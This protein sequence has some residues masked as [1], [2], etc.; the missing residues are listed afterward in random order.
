MEDQNLVAKRIVGTNALV[1][2]FRFQSPEFPTYFLTHAHSD[3]TTGLLEREG[4]LYQRRGE[5][6]RERAKERRHC[7]SPP[8]P[9]DPLGRKTR[10]QLL[11]LS[12]PLKKKKKTG[13]TRGFCAGTIYCSPVTAAL[14]IHDTPR[15]RDQARVVALEVGKTHKIRDGK[16]GSFE[17]TLVDANHCP[18]ACVLVFDVPLAAGDGGDGDDDEN[19]EG[20]ER[21]RT[22]RIVHTGD[23]RFHSSLHGGPPLLL[24]SPLNPGA[25]I[26]TLLL[27]TTYAHPRHDHPG[28]ELAIR[29]CAEFCRREAAKSIS[30]LQPLPS[31]V[32]PRPQPR[33]LFVFGSY[34]IGKERLYL[35][36]AEELG[37]KIWVPP[38]KRRLLEL[39]GLLSDGGDGGGGSEKKSDGG[40]GSVKKNGGGGESG[41][42]ERGGGESGGIGDR[43]T[44][45]HLHRR[46]PRSLLADSP[47]AAVLHVAPMG[48]GFLF[49]LTSFF[50]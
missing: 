29:A 36:V 35:G 30:P 47:T 16:C 15:V 9:V 28:Q 5:R 11:S 41:G 44:K 8:F 40:G 27:D 3:H 34:R 37:W 25:P 23:F 18:G 7:F 31:S 4:S 45:L 24:S 13:L 10:P 39:L 6:E 42:G 32:Q 26:D 50:L 46:Y 43:K 19:K 38:Q 33:P 12:P 2:G 21:T 1:D 14:I 48:K 49:S 17:V 20:T 22:R